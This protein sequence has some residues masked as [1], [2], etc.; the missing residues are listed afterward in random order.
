MSQIIKIFTKYKLQG[1]QFLG[2]LYTEHF[3]IAIQFYIIEDSY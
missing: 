3:V 1:L 2:T